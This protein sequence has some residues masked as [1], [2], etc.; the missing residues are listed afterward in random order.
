MYRFFVERK[1]DNNKFELTKDIQNHLKVLRL[2]KDEQFYCIY[3]KRIYL[4]S[5]DGEFALINKELDIDNEF[6]HNV[7][8]CA[9]IINIKRYEWL[10]QKATEL[11]VKNF[12]PLITKNTNPKYVDQFISKKNR[13]N[14]ISKNAAEQSFRNEL[15]IIHDPIKF[16][17]AIN[18][19]IENKFLAHEKENHLEQDIEHFSSDVAFYVGPEGGFDNQEI[20]NAVSK[21]VKIISLGKR[22]LRSETAS[23]YLLSRIKSNN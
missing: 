7:V 5:Q 18:M 3:Q 22:I 4:C 13:M 15:M 12:Y 23:L 2:K 8:L 19:E 11:G 14:E 20:E 9:S 10:I 21:K 17:D 16:D 6:K 1:V